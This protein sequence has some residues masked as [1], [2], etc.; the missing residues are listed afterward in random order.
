MDR[1]CMSTR[2]PKLDRIKMSAASPHPGWPLSSAESKT[3]DAGLGRQ[4]VFRSVLNNF[5]SLAKR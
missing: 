3:Y 1:R 2:F 5:K 4:G